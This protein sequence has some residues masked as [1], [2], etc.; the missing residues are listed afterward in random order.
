MVLVMPTDL[1]ETE[2]K[3]IDD[4]LALLNKNGVISH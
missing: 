4:T 2:N 1:T 3:I